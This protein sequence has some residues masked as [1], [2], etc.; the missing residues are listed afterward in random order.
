M[1]DDRGLRGVM[2]DDRAAAHGAARVR[3]SRRAL[4]G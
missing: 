1:S 2:S 4:E 3:V